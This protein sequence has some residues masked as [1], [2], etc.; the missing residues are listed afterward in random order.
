[1]HDSQNGNPLYLAAVCLVASLGGLLFGFDTAVISGTFGFVEQQFSLTT[2]QVGWFGSSALA[3]CIVGALFAGTFGDRFGRKPVLLGSGVLFFVSALGSTI[4]PSFDALISARI[5][6]GI[7]IGMASVLAPLYISEFSPPRVRGRLVATYQLSIVLGILAAYFSNWA[8]LRCGATYVPGGNSWWNWI[9]VEDLWRGMFAVEMVPASVFTVLLLLVPESP[10]WLIMA[11]R[12]TRGL[13]VLA[14]VGGQDAAQSELAAIRA[15]L[16]QQPGRLRELL[17]PGLRKAMLVGVGLSVFGQLTGVNVVV[18]Y[19]PSILEDAG[20][21][22]A[23]ALQYQVALGVINLVATLFALAVIDRQ[24]RRPLLLGGMSVV[25]A[26]TGLVAFLF[27]LEADVALWIMT[28]LCVY[29]FCVAVSICA[30]IWVLTG[31]IFPARLRGRAMSIATFANWTTNGVAAL[32][33]PWYVDRFG[34]STG[35]AT[36]AAICLIGTVFFARLVPE[37][38]G[39]SLEEIEQFWLN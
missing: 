36:F 24:G 3:G 29:M 6:G 27:S 8:L 30:V 22:L 4:A 15:V 10:R 20:F 1:M 2:L 11:G 39:K 9:F 7:G 33:F 16:S 28:L 25:V 5:V 19:G 14:K 26:T 23:N 34:M 12:D 21:P 32:L 37:T 13:A 38:K 35:F 17:C 18:Y 31:E